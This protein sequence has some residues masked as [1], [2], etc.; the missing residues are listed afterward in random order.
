[1][2]HFPRRLPKVAEGQVL[3]LMAPAVSLSSLVKQ[4]L[5]GWEVVDMPCEGTDISGN[6]YRSKVR[7]LPFLASG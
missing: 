3:V 1:M 7:F 5:R 2:F 4:V 6:F